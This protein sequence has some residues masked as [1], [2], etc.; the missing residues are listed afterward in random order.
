[1]WS[2]QTPDDSYRNI[3]QPSFT[4]P[5]WDVYYIPI[6]FKM[7]QIYIHDAKSDDRQTSAPSTKNRPSLMLNMLISHSLIYFQLAV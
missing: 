3:L 2:G 6:L 4:N 1:M 5:K 7:E